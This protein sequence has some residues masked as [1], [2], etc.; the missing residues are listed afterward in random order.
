MT[1]QARRV[2]HVVCTDAFAGVERYVVDVANEAAARGW[3]VSV[4]GGQPVRMRGELTAGVA[5]T[6]GSSVPR[7]LAGVLGFGHA[8]VVHAHMTAAEL[9]GALTAPRLGARLVA[10]RHFAATRGRTVAGRAAGSLVRRRLTAQVAL[11]TFVATA[12]DGPAQIIPPGVRERAQADLGKPQVLMLG[13]LSPEKHPGDGLLA[14]ARSGLQS[15]GWR[16]VV[17][18]DGALRR[19]LTLQAGELGISAS[20][21]FVG[22]VDAPQRWLSESSV[23]LATTREEGF[24]LSVVEAMAHGVPVL[25]PDSGAHRET[26]GLPECLYPPGDPAVCAQGLRRLAADIE[27]RRRLGAQLRTRQRRLFSVAAHVDGLLAVYAG[28][29]VADSR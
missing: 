17:A 4:V 22:H 28:C 9:V 8:D 24:G 25:A 2:V 21:D 18:G 16:L 13:R 5:F 19:S 10:T 20:V 26:V 7:A 11:S 1:G 23:L 27:L 12:I 14:W 3:D 6:P 29:L 15:Q